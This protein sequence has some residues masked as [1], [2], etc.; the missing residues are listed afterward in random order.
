MK[1]ITLSKS[2]TIAGLSLLV[3]I[4]TVPFAEFYIFPKLIIAEN[5]EETATNIINNKRLFTVGIFLHL[6]TLICDVVVAWALYIFLKP[7]QK[8]FSLLVAWFRLIYTAMYLTSLVNLVKVLTLVSYSKDVEFVSLSENIN[9]Y[10][11]NFK[12][13]WSLGLLLFGIYLFLLGY[14][15]FKANYVPKVF[16]VLLMIAGLGYFVN[17]LGAFLIPEVNLDFLFFTYFGELIFMVWLLVKGRN[18]NVV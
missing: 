4:L 12:L 17:T 8:N 15:V 5:P 1:P 13:E 6:V 11:N 2:A 7:V 18:T 3:M 14:L 16:G 9:F 10:L